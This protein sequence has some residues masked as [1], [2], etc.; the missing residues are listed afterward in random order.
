MTASRRTLVGLALAGL[1]AASGCVDS[2]ACRGRSETCLSLTLSGD[3]GVTQTDQ[4]Q[5]MFMRMLKPDVPMM[6]LDSPQDLPLKVAVL[7]PDGPA[8]ISV[9]ALLTGQ[10]I[11]VTP[12]LDLDLR[13]GEHAQRKLT[14]YPPLPGSGVLPPDM[15]KSQPDLRQPVDL[16]DTSPD[17]AESPPDLS[18]PPP[19]LSMPPPPI[20][21][22]AP[23]GDL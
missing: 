12:E 18:M 17:L 3:T 23:R 15:A 16:S 9:R 13:N 8:T 19:D 6:S 1:W 11:G 4:L 22:A 7:W 5:V 14:L 21:L 2:D 20:D 10:L